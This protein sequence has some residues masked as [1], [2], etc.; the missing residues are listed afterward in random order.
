MKIKTVHKKWMKDNEPNEGQDDVVSEVEHGR[1]DDEDASE[2]DDNL[3]DLEEA[4]PAGD[5]ESDAEPSVP[6]GADPAGDDEDE[7][8]LPESPR[9]SASL[10]VGKM[11]PVS[12]RLEVVPKRALSGSIKDS[13]SKSPQAMAVPAAAA[14]SSAKGNKKR[15]KSEKSDDAG[16]G[17]SAPRKKLKLN[18]RGPTRVLMDSVC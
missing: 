14:Q 5:S 2:V 9:A 3:S 11:L 13:K 15:G 10:P 6:G 8:L 18:I 16:S 7:P 17:D 1:N 12:G 4:P